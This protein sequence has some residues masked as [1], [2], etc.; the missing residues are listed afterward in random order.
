MLTPPLTKS[1][2]LAVP[3]RFTCVT[4]ASLLAY[5]HLAHGQSTTG[6]AL[7]SEVSVTA[8]T[9]GET[10]FSARR[11]GS[12]SKSDLPLFET[13]QSITVLT[14][15]QMDSRQVTSLNQALQG[16][17]GVS[18][19]SYG[20]RGWDDFFIRGQRASESVYVDGLRVNQGN[21]VSNEIFGVERV[22]VLKGPASINFGL[23]QPGGMVNMI[24]KRPKAESFN[25][26]GV[27]VGSYGYKQLTFD[28]GRPLSE[29]GKSAFRVNGMISDQDD[30]T[31]FVYFKNKYLA[32]SLSL[33]LGPAT[34]LVLLAS[35]NKREY[36]RQQGLPLR[37]SLFANSAVNI[38]RSLFTGDPGIGPYQAKQAQVG[39][40]LTHQFSSGWKL[41][42][43]FRVT[44]MDMQGRA[45]FMGALNANG[46]T[47]AR[48]GTLQDVHES[49]V[50]LDSNVEKAFNIFGLKQTVMLGVDL[51]R[52]KLRNA[53]TSNCT[54]TPLNLSN[55]THNATIS[56]P[57]TPTSSN[58]TTISYAAFY[59]RDRVELSD[60]LS[61][62][63]AARQDY[64]DNEV[65]NHLKKTTS[66]QSLSKTTGN[67]ALMYQATPNI[68]P[69]ISYATSFLPLG[70]T[71]VNGQQFQPE[72]GQQGEAGVK[73]QFDQGR[74]NAAIAR[75]ELTRQNA[76]ATNPNNT[77]FSIQTGEQRTKGL[78]AEISADLRNGWSLTGS[79]S[80]T[81][82]RIT[83]D[84]TLPIGARLQNAP[85]HSASVWSNYLFRSGPLRGFGFGVGA[86]FEGSKTSPSVTYSIPSYTVADASVSYEGTGYR[87][88]LS[89]KNLF[90]K[91]YFAGVL[92]NNVV[93]LGD[94]RTVM[95]KTVFNF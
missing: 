91:E 39:Y 58:T 43:N 50:A 82:A 23:V 80:Y 65:E 90:D 5:P 59:V 72:T 32:P 70:D 47:Q 19:G 51:N 62:T 46:I 30:P 79:W 44:E 56:C 57:S 49:S 31:D 18:A 38:S 69:Y 93:P 13:P 83:R 53:T 66:K 22:E 29:S 73:F 26:V 40:A 81:D 64:A 20:R 52:D 24:S 4:L 28:L 14:R 71:D 77:S 35:F 88:L 84:T 54:V 74:I 7:L 55:P 68:A 76:L 37:G 92:N 61:L 78:E 10:G 11:A 36:L 6:E 15:E 42:Q 21:W 94:P 45:V 1:V 27:G 75:Y 9:D 17:A 85:L 3:L 33:D 86:R 12:T 89:I 25:E 87:V 41:Q 67:G 8:T 63:L 2:S 60:R 95:L 16:V 34:D 48:T